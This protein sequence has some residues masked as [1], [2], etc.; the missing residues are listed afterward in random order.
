MGSEMCIRDREAAGSVGHYF[1]DPTSAVADSKFLLDQDSTSRRI[2]AIQRV[3]DNFSLKS[4]V[5][6]YENLLVSTAQSK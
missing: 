5:D 2:A 4:I 6:Q 3:K 1:S